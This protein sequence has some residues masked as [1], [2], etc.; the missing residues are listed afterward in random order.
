M[1]ALRSSAVRDRRHGWRPG[2]ARFGCRRAPDRRRRRLRDHG[3]RRR[4][5]FVAPVAGAVA[6]TAVALIF[7]SPAHAPTLRATLE[8]GLT[9]GGLA[10]VS[11]LWSYWKRTRHLS[12][13]LLAVALFAMTLQDFE[14]LAAP[15]MLGFDSSTLD[16]P[17]F[18]GLRLVVAV[19][20]ATAAVALRPE[21]VPRERMARP[22]VVVPIAYVVLPVLVAVADHDVDG[23]F[24]RGHGHAASAT[25]V[26]LTAP[27]IALLL[28]AAGTFV[29][30]GRKQRDDAVSGFLAAAL[31]LLA[32]AYVYGL[33]MPGL[34]T[35]AVSG[36]EYLR[37]GAYGLIVTVALR[38][39]VL[40]SHLEQEDAAVRARRRLIDDLHDGM[41]QDLAFIAAYGAD[42][43]QLGPNHPIVVAARR[44][45][46]FSRGAIVD[47][48]ASDA[49][50]AGQALR[51]LAQELARRHDIHVKLELEREDLPPDA[52]DAVV[53]V[54]REAIVNAVQHGDAKNVIV[55]VRGHGRHLTLTIRDDGRG[56]RGGGLTPRRSSYGFRGM[57]HRAEVIGG[58]LR[59]RPAPG[60]GLVVELT[61]S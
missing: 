60:G 33:L 3:A 24:I 53:R 27:A 13:L 30:L 46:A 55:S 25:A 52:R 34:T 44:A 31:I 32:G 26:A 15:A 2:W 12:D 10:S 35:A 49:P 40:Q 58:E 22:L 18:L 61:V 5:K 14:F 8:T 56:L 19:L 48:A 16:S 57:R 7:R 17:A 38:M 28:A 6:V 9:I 42:L 21:I 23:W 50:T 20:F 47:L 43:V 1:T 37:A 11:L 39:R 41:A 29:S 36:G 4:W 51:A 54:T 45:L 59:T